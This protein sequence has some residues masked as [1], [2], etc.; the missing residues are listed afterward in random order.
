MSPTPRSRPIKN[1]EGVT[2]ASIVVPRKRSKSQAKTDIIAGSTSGAVPDS[3]NDG[4]GGNGTGASNDSGFTA[5][6]ISPTSV[7]QS[8]GA[9]NLTKRRRISLVDPA[10]ASVL[11]A[12]ES[13]AGPAK[14]ERLYG[15][16][17]ALINNDSN[18]DGKSDVHAD[19][20]NVPSSVNHSGD[21]EKEEEKGM[22]PVVL[23]S[24]SSEDPQLLRQ[25]GGN[26]GV[27]DGRDV[28]LDSVEANR[29]SGRQGSDLSG[30]TSGRVT[31]V[32]PLQVRQ[33]TNDPSRPIFFAYVPASPYGRKGSAKEIGSQGLTKLRQSLAGRIGQLAVLY[34]TRDSCAFP[35][36]MES[37]RNKFRLVATAS[38]T[39]PTKTEIP[40]PAVLSAALLATATVYDPSLRPT[41]KEAWGANLHAL[42]EQFEIATLTT[43]QVALTDLTGRPSINTSGN[44]MTLNQ[45]LAISQ[46]L[47]LHLDPSDWQL[48][49]EEKDVRV[50]LWWAVVIHDKWSSL[51]WGRP[52]GIQK[53]NFSVP[54]PRRDDLSVCS[55][56]LRDEALKSF[57]FAPAWCE[58]RTIHT[59]GDTF[60]ALCRLT[61]ILSDIIDEFYSVRQA[62]RLQRDEHAV[63][64]RV[65]DYLIALED[66]KHM[67]PQSL[68]CILKGEQGDSKTSDM[69]VK[70]PGTRSLQLSYLGVNL[71]LCRTA[72]DAV[73]ARSSQN[74]DRHLVAHNT[75]MHASVMLVEFLESLDQEDLGGFYLHYGS[76][77]LASCLSMLA[78]LCLGFSRMDESKSLSSCIAAIQRLLVALTHAHRSSSWDLAE[79]ALTRSR[80]I[81]PALEARVAS[82]PSF[83]A[84]GADEQS[85]S[86]LT[87]PVSTLLQSPQDAVDAASIR[88]A[89]GG[90]ADTGFVAMP[91][92]GMASINPGSKATAAAMATTKS[93]QSAEMMS[94]ASNGVNFSSPFLGVNAIPFDAAGVPYPLTNVQAG[95]AANIQQSSTTSTYGGEAMASQLLSGMELDW[96]ELGFQPNPNGNEP[97]YLM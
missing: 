80:A 48:P 33:V 91:G 85:S 63:A 26:G 17:S 44:F 42:M 59:P 53:Q 93:G 6:R 57:D 76:H 21:G 46:M 62:Q 1:E 34:A 2:I 49:Q 65:K 96:L 89:S 67:Q 72:L 36:L 52:S 66:W 86:Q 87:T 27:S 61:M 74:A 22:M 9:T 71:L 3:L 28:H 45:T 13:N 92:H 10:S 16:V 15:L 56:H 11:S 14:A 20:R 40:L 68:A 90:V 94:S 55:S 7:T 54:F 73:T 70:V 4:I 35:L 88:S 83:F 39:D 50:R 12:G 95:D 37:Q 43:V 25:A 38:Q 64:Q 84:G 5:V 51:C 77:H 8:S 41:S 81:L 75:A 79:L 24:S 29:Q 31:T 60:A 47:G 78:R 82:F 97:P 32:G 19:F 58:E 69:A 18:A 30:S 23:G